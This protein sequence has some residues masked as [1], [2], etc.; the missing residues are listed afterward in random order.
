MDC[1]RCGARLP[2]H[3]EGDDHTVLVEC[4]AC[5]NHRPREDQARDD[6]AEAGA[7][8]AAVICIAF[9]EAL[10]VVAIIAISLTFLEAFT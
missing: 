5:W 2:N 8:V 7:T 6:D 3:L 4:V 1:Q 10:A 9:V